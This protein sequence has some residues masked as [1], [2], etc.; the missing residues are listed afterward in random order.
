MHITQGNLFFSQDED[1]WHQHQKV[2]EKQHFE[3]NF[4]ILYSQTS[5][6]NF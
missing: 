2:F 4:F 3:K 6:Q 5:S 1:L